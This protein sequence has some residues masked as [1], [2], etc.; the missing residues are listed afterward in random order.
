LT[1]SIQIEP[2][3][4]SAHF[5]IGIIYALNGDRGSALAHYKKLKEL[6]VRI[7]KELN[8]LIYKN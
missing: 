5:N 3:N 8:E 7:A 1:R 4:A 2:N 6:D